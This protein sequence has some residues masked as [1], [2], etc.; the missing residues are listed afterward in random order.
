M[1]LQTV[2]MLVDMKM[3]NINNE[4]LLTPEEVH[5][6]LAKMLKDFAEFC[7]QNK[8]R[9]YLVGGTLL[10]AVRHKGFI[11]WDDDIDVGMPRPDYERFLDLVKHNPISDDYKVISSREGTLPMPFA[12]LVNVKTRLERP[13]STYIAEGSQQLYLFLDIFPQDGWPEDIAKAKRL[14]KKADWKRFLILESRAKLGMGTS[15]VRKVMKTPFI[16]WGR[17]LGTNRIC[18]DLDKIGKKYDYDSSK[19]VGAVTNGVYGVGERCLREEV[20][21]FAS[22]EF[23]GETYNAPGCWDSY[24]HGIFGDYMKLPPKDK[25]ISHSLKVWMIEEN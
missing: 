17:M 19:Y 18:M 16:L 24:L 13:T 4:R 3:T 7:E 10:G 14:F 6:V 1:V 22:V 9:Y 8:L 20:V 21:A 23:E 25:Q 11:P 2:W 5:K 12:E 15:F